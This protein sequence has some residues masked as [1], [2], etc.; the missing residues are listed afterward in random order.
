MSDLII[1][2]KEKLIEIAD[3]IRAKTGSSE[4]IGFPSEFAPAIEGITAG[5]GSS[6][7]LQ[8]KTAWPSHDE[9]VIAPDEDYYGLVSVKVM[10]VPRVPA[11]ESDLVTRFVY[12][13]TIEQIVNI[14]SETSVSAEDVLFCYE[15]SSVSGASYGFSKTSDGYYTSNNK[16]KN[17]SYAVCKIDFFAREEK[18]IILNCINYAESN[19]DYGLISEIDS[20][21]ELN[22][23]ADSTGVFKSFKGESS[24]DVIPLSIT[25]P[26]GDHFV[27]VKFIKDGSGNENNDA[28]KFA[29]VE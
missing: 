22:Y 8:A 21:L 28:F 5:G 12:P 19:Y 24:P 26:A 29:I 4:P 20:T 18:T 25:V 16:A 3:A 2:E 27:Y 6:G 14:Y 13:N 9:Q 23:D 11:C 10:P 1:C 15:V 7:P 17:S